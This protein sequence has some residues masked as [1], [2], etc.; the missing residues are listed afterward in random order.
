[1]AWDGGTVPLSIENFYV[2][3]SVAP[4][5]S[6]YT[7]SGSTWSLRWTYG[8]G[9]SGSGQFMS[10]TGICV[11]RTQATGGGSVF[12]SYV[13]VADAGNGRLVR[14]WR[15]GTTGAV[16]S[17]AVS[18]PDGGVP[19]DCA[20]DHFG[21]VYVT[22]IRNHRLLKYTSGMG[23][24]A[25]Y[26]SHGVGST[27]LNTFAY[28]RSIH[29]P[30]G[31]AMING[32]VR[33]QGQGRVFTGEAWS[34]QSGAVE[35]WL[36]VEVPQATA[37]VGDG[38]AW[39]SSQITDHANVTIAVAPASG[40]G[41][42]KALFVAS[43][44]AAGSVGATWDGLKDNGTS[45]PTGY[46]RFYVEAR[47]A[48]GCYAGQTWCSTYRYSQNFH[49]NECSPG[50]GGIDPSKVALDLKPSFAQWQ[51]PPCSTA[52]PQ[53]VSLLDTDV[54]ITGVAPSQF[55]VRQVLL[56]Q[57]RPLFRVEGAGGA[58][59][60]SQLP[61][62]A[63]GIPQFVRQFGVRGLGIDIPSAG[64]DVP[65]R[66]RVY[67]LRG[68]LVRELVNEQLGPGSYAIGWDGLDSSGR[69][70]QPGVYIALMT[71]GSYR[72]AARLIIK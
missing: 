22:D 26:G 70:V 36:G 9:G 51:P 23:L 13:Y 56:D 24:L 6:Y 60:T 54:E 19:S 28:P 67:D 15:N 57:P 1:V 61:N 59:A 8:T 4:F 48:Y 52:N 63:S 69:Q 43:F 27:S 33:W 62:A 71:A 47:S 44:R 37:S 72:G 31:K 16:W 21:N 65:V 66:V 55:A 29:I 34:D 10:P 2:L 17:N 40:S 58:R 30:F 32:Q 20:V 11:G 64:A 3:N 14:L 18:L 39:V 68:H 25:Q 46:Y 12:T 45:A 38:I 5:V 50:G 53:N 41:T 42:T 35:H 7:G 49:W